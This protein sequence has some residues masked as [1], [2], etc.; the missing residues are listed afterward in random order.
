MFNLPL[1]LLFCLLLIEISFEIKLQW[2]INMLY[3]QAYVFEYPSTY[4]PESLK[5]IFKCTFYAQLYIH[6]AHIPTI[7][8]SLKFMY[9]GVM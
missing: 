3:I 8:V 9:S 1:S 7:M 4:F 6:E 2:C 5:Y